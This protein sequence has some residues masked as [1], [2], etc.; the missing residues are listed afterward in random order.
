MY[1]G[2]LFGQLQRQSLVFVMLSHGSSDNQTQKLSRLWVSVGPP[3][4]KCCLLGHALS[5]RKCQEISHFCER[6]GFLGN[7]RNSLIFSDT[8]FRLKSKAQ[9]D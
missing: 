4:A 1:V 5:N 6:L 8:F 7:A 2:L 9:L 3:S